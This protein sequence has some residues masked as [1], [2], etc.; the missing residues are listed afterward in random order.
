VRAR[1]RTVHAHAFLPDQFG[2]FLSLFAA[3]I[4][5][6]RKRPFPPDAVEDT[7]LVGG[8]STS[9]S[10][11]V[12]RLNRNEM[13]GV[14]CPTLLLLAWL[15]WRAERRGTWILEYLGTSVHGYISKYHRIVV[16]TDKPCLGLASPYRA[17]GRLCNSSCLSTPPRP[18]HNHTTANSPQ[19]PIPFPLTPD[20]SILTDFYDS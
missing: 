4:R 18:A 13:A 10:F 12:K 5:Q 17:A 16:L 2:S 7:F 11:F 1:I 19:T 8:H 15:R 3:A 20:G 9:G 6:G 14:Q